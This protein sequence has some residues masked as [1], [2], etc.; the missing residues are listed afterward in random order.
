MQVI[1]LPGDLC[2]W[3]VDRFDPYSVTLYISKHK[4]IEITPM[5]MHI[6][7]ALPIGGKKV[8]E[9]Y[10]KKPK[11]AKYNEVLDA[12]RKN[13]NLQ[14]G[15]PKLSQMP[16]YILSQTDAAESF[17]RNFVMYLVSCFF[18]S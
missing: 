8:E 7:L 18:N 9:Y 3:L 6:T 1:E 12:W 5:D 2:K 15:T 16:Q 11:D 10:R 17:K 13:W 4:R 14:D